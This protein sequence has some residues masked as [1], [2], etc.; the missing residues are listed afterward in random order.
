MSMSQ[1]THIVLHYSATYADES[2]TA[3][4]IDKMHKGRG[5]RGIG[6]HW[7]IRRDGTVE[8]GR[9]ES[10]VGAHVGGQ[11]SGK[12]GVC[13][14]GG[15]E[16]E[17]GSNVG[18]DNRTPKQIEA[19]VKLIREIL[20][21]HPGARV[22]G[23]RDLAPTQCPGFDVQSWWAK[24][25]HRKAPAPNPVSPNAPAKTERVGEDIFHVV[26]RGDTWWSIAEEHGLTLTR[27]LE[28]N[29]ADADDVLTP[30][31]LLTVLDDSDEPTG[32]VP[33]AGLAAAV[34]ATLIAIFSFFAD[35]PCDAFGVFCGG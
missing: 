16:R 4:D 9:P 27:L 5:W 18:V 21:R 30:G 26:A 33:A 10:Q 12:I 2:V 25:Q 35:L 24:V 15:L 29:E 7:F 6:Y 34:A 22:V 31:R 32:K 13:C 14:A 1:V 19:Q 28:L 8:Q 17:T 23:H 11:N 20:K 3:A